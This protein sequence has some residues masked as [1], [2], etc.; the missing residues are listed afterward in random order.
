MPPMVRGASTRMLHYCRFKPTVNKK[1]SGYFAKGTVVFSADFE[2]AWAYRYSKTIADFEAMARREREQVPKLLTLFA[3][4]DIPVTWATVGHLFLK[5]CSKNKSG[6]THDEMTRPPHFS[7]EHWRFDHGDWYQHDPGTDLLE[8]PEWY[9]PDLI[10][11]IKDAHQRNEIACH[12]FSHIDFSYKNCPK[13]LA[14]AELSVCKR[15]A[16]ESG[17]ELT[18]MVFPGGTAGNY[19]SLKEL[20][21]TCYRKKAPFDIDVP[22]IDKLGLVSIPSGLGLDRDAYGWSADFHIRKFRKILEYASKNRQLCSFWFH[23]SMDPWYFEN[24]MPKILQIV[25]ERVRS[26]DLLVQTMSELARNVSANEFH[27]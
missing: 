16:A 7:N 20:G 18:S 2:M 26:G 25:N 13:E 15:L 12:T 19:E 8:N 21:F 23:P 24:V 11:M 3:D 17:C 27:N 22:K 4:L 14:L 1:A 10:R 5:E 9:A 6:L